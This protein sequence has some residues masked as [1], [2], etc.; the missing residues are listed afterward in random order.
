M[1]EE[2]CLEIGLDGLKY[3]QLLTKGYVRKLSKLDHYSNNTFVKTEKTEK[4]RFV[5]MP[6]HQKRRKKEKERRNS[7]PSCHPLQQ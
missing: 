2:K 5:R 1:E 3:R 7:K 6:V 4:E